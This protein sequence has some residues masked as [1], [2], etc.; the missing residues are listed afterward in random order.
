MA[1]L[2]LGERVRR[3]TSRDYIRR[4]GDRCERSDLV[5]S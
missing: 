1:Y 3:L 5:A 4:L 2:A